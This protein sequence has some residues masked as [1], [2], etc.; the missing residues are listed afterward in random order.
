MLA[1]SY[2]DNETFPLHLSPEQV[3]SQWNLQS[4]ISDYLKYVG[5]QSTQMQCIFIP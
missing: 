5:P 2:I 1:Q 3:D 4:F